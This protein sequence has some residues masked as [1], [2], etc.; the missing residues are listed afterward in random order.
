MSAAK[1]NWDKSEALEVGKWPGGL[2]VLPERLTWKPDGLKY[3]SLYL[4]NETV[5]AKNWK[6]MRE[7]IKGKMAKWG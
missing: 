6:G 2:T 7:K 4:G 3:L 1:I 5:I